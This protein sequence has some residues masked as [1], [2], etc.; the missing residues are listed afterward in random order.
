MLNMPT[1]DI[2]HTLTHGHNIDSD[3]FR[4]VAELF[5]TY[6]IEAIRMR[7]AAAEATGAA[8]NQP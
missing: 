1:T 7:R 5:Q 8:T 2:L 3:D 6:V 4:A